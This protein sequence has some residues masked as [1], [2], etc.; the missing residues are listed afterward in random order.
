[1][2]LHV[3]TSFWLFLALLLAFSH[4]CS[5]KGPQRP[6]GYYPVQGTVTMDGAP[7]EKAEIFFIPTDDSVG[8]RRSASVVNGNYSFDGDQSLKPRE[9]RIE[10]SA[11]REYDKKTKGEINEATD[12]VDIASEQLIPAKYNT[13]SELKATVT[14]A[15][16]NTV[17]FDLTP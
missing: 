6:E 13:K 4:G 12:P 2:N 5:S 7:L 15:G 14:E 9:Y 1:M 11:T 10:I 17:D 16:S 3:P 8:E